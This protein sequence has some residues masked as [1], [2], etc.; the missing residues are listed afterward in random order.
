MCVCQHETRAQLLYWCV[1]VL[2]L[3]TEHRLLDCWTWCLL[4]V[5]SDAFI[6]SSFSSSSSTTW[7]RI[8]SGDFDLALVRWGA[9]LPG[10]A[11]INRASTKLF[12]LFRLIE[13]IVLPLLF[14]V[15]FKFSSFQEQIKKHQR[16]QYC[17]SGELSTSHSPTIVSAWQS[18]K[19]WPPLSLLAAQVKQHWPRDDR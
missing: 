12:R 7:L 17:G 6:L 10:T 14:L 11:T 9:P 2:E 4:V 15:Y 1:R 16:R 5:H 19:C 3:H 13:V 8:G 18:I